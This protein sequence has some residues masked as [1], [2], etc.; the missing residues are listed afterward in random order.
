MARRRTS[1]A[2]DLQELDPSNCIN[3][4]LVAAPSSKDWLAE[5]LVAARTIAIGAELIPIPCVRVAF[6][7][8]VLFLET[9]NKIKRNREDLKDL[10]G[11]TLEIMMILE[12]GTKDHEKYTTV[13]FAGLV[14]DFISSLGDLHDGLER[15]M[16]Q[17][18]GFRGAFQQFLR[19]TSITEEIIRYR[20][21]I[22]ELRLNFLLMTTI[23]THLNVIGIHKSIATPEASSSTLGFRNIALGDINLLY[24]TAMRN[25][26]QKVKIFIAR[27]SGEASLMTVAQYE[28][29]AEWQNDLTLYSA[30]RHPNLWQLFGFSSAPALRALIFHEELIPLAIYRQNHRPQSDL[31]WAC[32]EAMLVSLRFLMRVFLIPFWSLKKFRQFKDCS[33]YHRWNSGDPGHV[34]RAAAICV[35]RE[36][37]GICLTMPGSDLGCDVNPRERLLSLWHTSYFSHRAPTGISPASI[38]CAPSPKDFVPRLSWEQFLAMLTPAWLPHLGPRNTETQF[39]LGSIVTG[40]HLDGYL[41]P[42]SPVAHLDNSSP[43]YLMQWTLGPPPKSLPS[44]PYDRGTR[45]EWQRLTFPPGSFK[46]SVS[47][48]RVTVL[49][50]TYIEFDPVNATRLNLSWLAQANMCISPALLQGEQP[51][52]VVDTLGS[53][54]MFDPAFHHILHAEGIPE[55]THI[56]VCPITVKYQGSRIG[57]EGLQS[58]CYYWSLDAAGTCRLSSEECDSLGIPRLQVGPI[59]GANYWHEYHYSA[60]REFALSKGVDLDSQDIA[61][62][63][64]LPKV[65]M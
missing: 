34:S 49:M 45:S 31:I 29:G 24:D 53:V 16:Q 27:I 42:M 12:E 21:R 32:V 55:E 50:S 18:R 7:I 63:L 37:V 47:A 20:T 33:D 62:L 46:G 10:C 48:S 51:H 40:E 15:F 65:Q 3:L 6:G 41:G 39:F 59:C 4:Q 5:M 54:I 2:P 26:T 44:N 19:A 36:P 64:G 11:T 38:A 35:K 22:Q 28:N 13:R 57:V 8:A 43:P 17:R 25:K 56:F 60:I 1:A 52:G 9:V 58:D 61:Q 23:N 30:L 14:E